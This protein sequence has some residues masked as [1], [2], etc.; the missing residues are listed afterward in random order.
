MRVFGAAVATGLLLAPLA[1]ADYGRSAEIP[2]AKQPVS[3]VLGD[4]NQDGF[5]D[6]VTIY[7]SG[8]SISALPG[9]GDGSFARPV[10]YAVTGARSAVFGDWDSDGLDDVAVAAAGATITVFAGVDGK[11]ER[12][13]SYPAPAPSVLAAADLDSDGNLDLAAAS[14]TEARVSVLI[15]RGDETFDSAIDYPTASA[16]SSVVVADLDGDDAPDIATGGSK[17]SILFGTG[18]GNLRAIYG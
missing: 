3:V 16:A 13:A 10:D 18:D 5:T 2:L 6:L 17:P 8:A 9:R 12:K 11:L 7:S 1:S 4:A 14:S 15:G